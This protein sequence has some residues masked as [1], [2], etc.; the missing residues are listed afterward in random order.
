MAVGLARTI[1]SESVYVDS[2]GIFALQNSSPSLF[3]VTVMNEIGIGIRRELS[4]QITNDLAY[5]YDLILCME[6]I[7]KEW[8]ISNYPEIENRVFLLG[9]FG[10]KGKGEEI[11]DPIGRGIEDYRR[12]RDKIEKEIKRAFKYLKDR[13]YV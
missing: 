7:H 4:K 12:C 9:E 2:A 3:T 1:V 10:K 5:N 11:G 6:K 13:Y 8:T